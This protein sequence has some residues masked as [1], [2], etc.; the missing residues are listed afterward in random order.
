MRDA[1]LVRAVLE[2]GNM[3]H[4]G[5]ARAL[6]YK[7]AKTLSRWLTGET[8]LNPEAADQLRIMYLAMEDKY[9]DDE[10]VRYMHLY[11]ACSSALCSIRSRPSG[12]PM[13]VRQSAASQAH[14]GRVGLRQF[15]VLPA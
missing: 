11:A 5:L 10:D 15:P 12:I 8:R 9:G 4:A 6:R 2:G 3:T 14:S 13:P 1:Q 7:S